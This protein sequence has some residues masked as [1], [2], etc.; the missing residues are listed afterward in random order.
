MAKFVKLH[1][2]GCEMLINLDKVET[3][4]PLCDGGSMLMMGG[5]QQFADESYDEIKKIIGAAQG[6]IPMEPGRMY[7]GA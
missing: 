4:E 5:C 2:D 6:G 3:V 1:E 7:D